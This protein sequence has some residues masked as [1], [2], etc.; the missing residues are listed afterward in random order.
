MAH[1]VS[2]TIS[3]TDDLRK[4]FYENIPIIDVRTP[5]EFKSTAVPN[6]V[7]LPLLTEDECHAIGIHFEGDT[8]IGVI[9]FAEDSINI[10]PTPKVIV[11]YKKF[12]EKH[13]NAV[14]SCSKDGRRS[15]VIQQNLYEHRQWQ[16]P[17]VEGGICSLNKFLIDESEYLGCKTDFFLLSGKTGSGKTRLLRKL[18]NTLNLEGL[19]NHRGSAF[20]QV[21]T[22]QPGQINFENELT[23]AQIQ[24][25]KDHARRVL[26]EDENQYIGSIHLPKHLYDKMSHAPIILMEVSHQSR[27]NTSLQEYVIDTLEGYRAYYGEEQAFSLYRQ[28][29]LD[30]LKKIRKRLGEDCYKKLRV[31]AGNAL[32]QQERTGSVEAHIPWVETLLHD[33]YDPMY[34]Y[35]IKNKKDRIIYSGDAIEVAEYWDTYRH[36][37]WNIT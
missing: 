10:V 32:N 6:S 11:T 18:P 19:A 31:L 7:N 20:G 34:E 13:P 17:I 2:A 5:G 27:L 33:Y 23:Y 16:I 37:H 22:K 28:S 12:R 35:L 26:I 14:L 30:S 9:E 3:T 36:V 25:S 24:L 8:S 1:Q 4:L 15:A 21:A 29:I